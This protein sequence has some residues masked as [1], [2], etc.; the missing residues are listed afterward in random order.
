L[1]GSTNG[2]PDFD[3]LLRRARAHAATGDWARSIADYK[4]AAASKPTGLLR[5]R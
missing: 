3:L 1:E 4:A 2:L 5:D